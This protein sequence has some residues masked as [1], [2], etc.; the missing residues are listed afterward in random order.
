VTLLVLLIL[1]ALW[2]V[3]LVPPL[4]RARGARSVDSVGAFRHRLGV[5]GRT[6]GGPRQP[7]M[8]VAAA[9]PAVRPYRTF[10]ANPGRRVSPT[11]AKRRRDVLALLASG[12]LV[13]LAGAALSGSLM[14]W[15]LFV[16]VAGSLGAYVAA[17]AHL[18]R[19]AQ[20]RAVKVRY[21][22]RR[23]LAPAPAIALRR[24]AGS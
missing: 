12:S 20:E 6:H 11:V 1:A 21:L 13:T 3:V 18:Q 7:A 23:R 16:L 2:A 4:M 10:A 17:L 24:T 15:A 19:S 22:P 8:A 9:H 14:F 5:L